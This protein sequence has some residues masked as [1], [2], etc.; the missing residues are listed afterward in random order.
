MRLTK[1]TQACVLITDGERRVLIDPT[2]ME[3][4]AAELLA[5]TAALLVTHGHRDHV[6][7]AMLA[8][9]LVARADLSVWAPRSVAEEV[10]NAMPDAGAGFAGTLTSVVQGDELVAG[11]FGVRVF[12]GK[13]AEIHPDMDTGENVAYLVDGRVYHPGDSFFAPGEPIEV[14]LLPT[15]GPWHTTGGA[16][17]FVRTVAPRRAIQIHEIFASDFGQNAMVQRIAGAANVQLELVPNGQ[18]VEV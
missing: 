11:G 9:A 5:S 8:E 15:S 17:D 2:P 10:R 3:P 1:F 7:P 14:L 6:D 16:M 12:G 4:R 18:E 13:H